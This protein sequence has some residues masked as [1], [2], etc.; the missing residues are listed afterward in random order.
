MCTTAAVLGGKSLATQIS[1]KI[2]RFWVHTWNNKKLKVSLLEKEKK[3]KREHEKLFLAIGGV[4]CKKNT[5]SRGC[6]K[7]LL[8][9][10]FCNCPYIFPLVIKQLTC[11]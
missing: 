5:T 10:Y 11:G 8:R 7:Y 6:F 1:E 2:V 3:K 9:G 4:V